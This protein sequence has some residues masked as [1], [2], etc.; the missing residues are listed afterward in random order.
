ML[1]QTRVGGG[2]HLTNVLGPFPGN[3]DRVW[4]ARPR[5]DLLA[6]WA[7]SLLFA[8]RAIGQK[9]SA[10]KIQES[11]VGFSPASITRAFRPFYPSGRR[12]TWPGPR[13]LKQSAFRSLEHAGVD[14]KGPARAE[15]FNRREKGTW[16]HFGRGCASRW[17]RDCGTRLDA[18]ARGDLFFTI[19]SYC[20]ELGATVNVCRSSRSV[21][22]AR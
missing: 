14:G 16:I 9:K 22:P 3:V 2:D 12:L 17:R 18:Q 7:G 21:R 10:L 6:P 11:W 15:P 20:M 8:L 1:A 5:Q 19:Q 4:P 13:S